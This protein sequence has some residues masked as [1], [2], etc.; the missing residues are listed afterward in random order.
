MN[1]EEVPGADV[2]FVAVAAVVLFMEFIAA[3]TSLEEFVFVV[4]VAVV[5]ENCYEEDDLLRFFD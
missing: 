2:E 4:V 1:V 3:K 5:F